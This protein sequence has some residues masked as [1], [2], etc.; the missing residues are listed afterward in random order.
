MFFSALDGKFEILIYEGVNSGLNFTARLDKN[1][2]GDDFE[3]VLECFSLRWM[4]K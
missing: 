3:L 4:A 1:I 2:F